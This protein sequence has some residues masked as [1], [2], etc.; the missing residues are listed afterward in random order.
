[1]QSLFLLMCYRW[2]LFLCFAFVNFSD[3]RFFSTQWADK[4]ITWIT[5]KSI[6]TGFI[7]LSFLSIPASWEFKALLLRNKKSLKS[8]CPV[9]LKSSGSSQTETQMSS[10]AG[11]FGPYQE[12]SSKAPPLCSS[13]AK[14]YSSSLVWIMGLFQGT[15]P[16]LWCHTTANTIL[17]RCRGLLWRLPSQ[18]VFFII[19]LSSLSLWMCLSKKNPRENYGFEA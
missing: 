11:M 14:S 16:S 6:L 2:R 8:S 12:S 19:Q 7:G 15:S 5:E 3:S 18:D 13:G 1:M 9:T 10:Q 17:E 4:E